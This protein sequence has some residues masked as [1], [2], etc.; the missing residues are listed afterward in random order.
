[1]R[2]FAKQ[3][4]QA[5][6]LC[7]IAKFLLFSQIFTFQIRVGLLLFLIPKVY[8]SDFSITDRA[9]VFNVEPEF[10][11]AFYQFWTF[12]GSGS[13]TF[14]ERYSLKAGVA[15][16]NTNKV[17]EL[18]AFIKGGI[19]LPLAFRSRQLPLAFNFG[20]LYN[21][22]PAYEARTYTILPTISLNGRWVGFSLGTTLRFTS[23]SGEGAVFESILAFSG[24]VNF[25]NTEKLR[26]GLQVANFN[27]YTAGNFGAYYLT[28]NSMVSII[29][30]V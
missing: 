5:I 27:D 1:V 26:V 4:S 12:S 23:F 8:A 3:N 20:Y 19:L 29:K 21:G 24:Y 28:L 22:L 18:D 9:A 6:P 7:G 17:S 10:N 13:L 11:R 25:Y 30:F 14:N 16:W 2:S 15:L